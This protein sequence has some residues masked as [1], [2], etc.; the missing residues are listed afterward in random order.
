MPANIPMADRNSNNFP[1]C[2]V[3]I[4]AVFSEFTHLQYLCEWEK[5][6]CRIR[7]AKVS[8][9]T[10][11]QIC[12][13]P[14]F[15]SPNTLENYHFG[16]TVTGLPEPGCR[17]CL[18]M[19]RL[20]RGEKELKIAI[21]IIFLRIPLPISKSTSSQEIGARPRHA[22]FLF[23]GRSGN[24]LDQMIKHNN[25]K[26]KGFKNKRRFYKRRFYQCLAS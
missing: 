19:R 5:K 6:Q 13:L 25:N 21:V 10:L 26:K 2:F 8:K 3:L 22:G 9:E 20:V 18:R 14:F 15:S 12:L 4:S 1:F 7:A 23:M 17:P 11:P 24:L 16:V